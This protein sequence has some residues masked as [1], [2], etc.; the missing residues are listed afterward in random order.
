[1][2]VCARATSKLCASLTS[3][4]IVA[5][6]LFSNR[7]SFI[8]KVA[9]QSG[10][11]ASAGGQHGGPRWATRRSHPDS[12]C[13]GAAPTLCPVAAQMTA[14]K[15]SVTPFSHEVLRLRPRAG[16]FSRHGRL[17]RAYADQCIHAGRSFFSPSKGFFSNA[18]EADETRA[19]RPYG[20]G[21]RFLTAN[22]AG[23]E[24]NTAMTPNRF[25]TCG[26]VVF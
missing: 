16:V 21:L 4:P 10:R 17:P 3:A 15:G 6:N 13:S 8:S 12:P 18:N 20:Q 9:R 25:L 1:M 22:A 19:P 7:L 5:S 2:H 24:I 26:V 23:N 11:A 14:T